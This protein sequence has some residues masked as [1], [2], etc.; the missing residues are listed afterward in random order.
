MVRS[1]VDAAEE[2]GRAAERFKESWNHMSKAGQRARPA[3]RAARRGARRVVKTA[4]RAV[5]KA[6]SRRKK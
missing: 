4:K 3:T 5:R 2:V 6:V 1:A